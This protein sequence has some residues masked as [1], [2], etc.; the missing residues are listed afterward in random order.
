MD[1]ED[2][3]VGLQSAGGKEYVVAW[4]VIHIDWQQHFFHLE[5]LASHE[6]LDVFHDKVAEG[7]VMHLV[8]PVELIVRHM[9]EP[10]TY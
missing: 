5:L 2:K 10:F 7:V 4:N 3:L 1:E 8:H 9:G 6:V